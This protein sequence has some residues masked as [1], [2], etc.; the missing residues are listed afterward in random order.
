MAMTALLFLAGLMAVVVWWLFKQSVNVQPWVA[1]GSI[2]DVHPGALDRP[3]AKTALLIFLCVVTSLFA[4]FMSAYGM[5]MDLGDWRPLQEPQLLWWNT[6]LLAVT[7]I[8]MQWTVVAAGRGDAGGVRTALIG[9]GVL[10]FA[11]LAGQLVVWQQLNNAG[12]FLTA[13]PANAFF[14]L[15]TALHGVHVLGGLVAWGR[16]AA[17]VWRGI[18]VA[19]VRL[20]VE[21]CAIYWH[22]LFLVWV[23]LFALLLST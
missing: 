20:S 4:L 16:T 8:V 7:S 14:Y 10:T 11:F 13:N 17:K 22:F 9:G 2:R 15:L 12:Y 23:A 19:K 21:L 18:E 1:H 6:G 5:R 3:A